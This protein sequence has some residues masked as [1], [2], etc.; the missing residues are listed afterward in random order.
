MKNRET[1]SQNDM[2]FTCS[3]IEKIARDT[4]NTNSSV[5]NALGEDGIKY[6]IKN[7]QVLHCENID[8]VSDEM[9]SKYGINTGD[10]DVGIYS[11]IPTYFDMG[12]IYSRLILHK[13]RKDHERKTKSVLKVYNSPIAELINNYDVNM[14]V[15][16]VPYLYA[17]YKAKRALEY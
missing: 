17:S 13:I 4:N 3:L 6:I 1:K 2:F 7:A 8:K 10:Y 11:E 16:N 14:M 9:V 12:K 5:A 15:S